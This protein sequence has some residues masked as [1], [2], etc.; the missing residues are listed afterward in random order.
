MHEKLAQI[1]TISEIF[2]PTDD[3][4]AERILSQNDEPFNINF[5][6]DKGNFTINFDIIPVDSRNKF[7]AKSTFSC[8]QL[9][10]DKQVSVMKDEELKILSS[11]G[12]NNF[13]GYLLGSAKTKEPL[14]IPMGKVAPALEEFPISAK[15]EYEILDWN[16]FNSNAHEDINSTR[17]IQNAK[18]ATWKYD[19]AKKTSLF[20]LNISLSKDEE[21]KAHSIGYLTMDFNIH[22]LS[23]SISN[24]LCIDGSRLKILSGQQG[25][26]VVITQPSNK[27]NW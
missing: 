3:D 27:F 24:E 5:D 7:I 19:K 15:R 21:A 9:N 20:E 13:F 17:E 4:L 11:D 18:A 26:M 23:Q 6:I 16:N 22:P 1:V 14:L 12:N 25:D 10:N 8:L 2:Q